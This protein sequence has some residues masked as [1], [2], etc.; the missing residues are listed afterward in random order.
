MVGNSRLRTAIQHGEVETLDP[1]LIVNPHLEGDAFFWEG[2]ETG[3]LLSHGFTATTAEVRPLSRILHEHGY[4]VAGP[5]LPGHFTRPEELNRVYWRDWLDSVIEAY[6]RLSTRCRHVF[7]GGESTGALLALM[8]A[9]DHPE[10]AGILAY[11]P[12]LILKI[13]SLDLIRLALLAPFI[14]YVQEHK[15]VSGLPWQGYYVLPLKGALQLLKL[16][17]QVRACLSSIRQPVLIVQGVHDARVASHAP[18]IILQKISSSV[19]E[20]HWMAESS[21]VAILDRELEQVAEITLKFIRNNL[22]S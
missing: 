7:V 12:A 14:P 1:A 2:N 21:H 3:I 18:Q 11:A 9:S 8:L 13:T 16:Q 6:S 10:I 5:L 22:P 17:R 20:L 19:K 4:T 15:E